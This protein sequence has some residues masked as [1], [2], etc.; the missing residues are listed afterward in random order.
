[1]NTG[2]QHLTPGNYHLL[3]DILEEIQPLQIEISSKFTLRKVD[4]LSEMSNNNCPSPC[5]L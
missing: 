1:M 4:D 5:P 3:K 2:L